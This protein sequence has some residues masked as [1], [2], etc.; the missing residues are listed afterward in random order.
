MNLKKL[1]GK[2]E[3]V[4]ETALTS[5]NP[6]DVV[7]YNDAV[8]VVEACC[9][10]CTGSTPAAEYDKKTKYIG[11]RIKEHHESILEHSNLVI[12]INRS[13]INSDEYIDIIDSLQF[14][15]V[16]KDN[17]FIYIAGSVRG[18]KDFIKRVDMS[19]PL[20][21]QIFDCIALYIPRC[22]MAD[23]IEE[24]LHGIDEYT[25]PD[26]VDDFR[27]ESEF[28]DD[29][30]HPFTTFVNNI[31]DKAILDDVGD[32]ISRKR[33]VGVN[34]DTLST[35]DLN[36]SKWEYEPETASEKQE[37]FASNIKLMDFLRLGT[38]T[39]CFKNA[40]R[41]ATHQLVRHRNAIT[42]ESQRYVNYSN[43]SFDVAAKLKGV[44]FTIPADDGKTFKQFTSE[45]FLAYTK[46]AYDALIEAGV[47]KE[48]ARSIL[49]NATECGQLYMTFTWYNL[50]A[51]LMLRMEKH[52]QAEIREFANT[53]FD[54][55]ES[56]MNYILGHWNTTLTDVINNFVHW[57]VPENNP[58][59]GVEQLNLEYADD[60]ELPDSAFEFSGVQHEDA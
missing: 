43:A 28:T 7:F 45:S 23:I 20:P 13:M 38:V 53:L 1:F 35:L 19:K 8:T 57:Y 16:V 37:V 34:F 27:Y 4:Q 58:E 40:S 44:K 29:D 3:H 6:V 2:K 36:Y 59:L 48:D 60:D 22:L 31:G 47:P 21:K 52:A 5:A 26:R 25:F 10:C 54:L 9:R 11:N 14:L 33:V 15:R 39:V 41:A 12:K 50:C 42:Q 46:K 24:G 49:P 55:V 30:E 17:V 51:F 18:W 56:D 32:T